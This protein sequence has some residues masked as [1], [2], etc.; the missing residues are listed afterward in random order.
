MA[1]ERRS[2]FER[3]LPVPAEIEIDKSIPVGGEWRAA[4]PTPPPSFGR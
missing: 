3:S 2:S 1:S 4:A